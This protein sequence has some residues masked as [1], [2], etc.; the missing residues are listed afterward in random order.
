MAYQRLTINKPGYK[1]LPSLDIGPYAAQSWEISPDKL[2]LTMKLGNNYFTPLEPTRGRIMDAEDVVFTTRR[3]ASTAGNLA[4]DFFNSVSPAAPIMSV[5]AVDAKTVQ[6]KLKEPYVAILALL[7]YSTAGAM[8]IVP[9]EA[10]TF[11]LRGYQIGSGNFYLAEYEP[12]VRLVYKR[13][14]AYRDEP[15]PYVDTVELPIV[16]EYSVALAQ[17]KAGNVHIYEGIRAEDILATKREVPDLVL[18]ATDLQAS[19][20]RAFYG[21]RP[22]VKGA[23][24][25]V[26][27]RQ[28]FSMSWDRDLYIE[29]E[30]NV[31]AFEAEGLPM[32]TGWDTCYQCNYYPDWYLDPQ[33]KDFGE[34]AKYF[35]RDI[36]EAKKLVAAAG[37][38][39]G[40]EY[41]ANIPT[42]GFGAAFT[43]RVE[44]VINMGIDAGLKPNIVPVNFNTDFRPK[45]TLA[46]GDFDGMCYVPAV[47][48]P[49]PGEY[50]SAHYHT[51]GTWFNGF[52][53]DGALTRAGD[54]WMNKTIEEMRREFDEKK[55][56]AL[57]HEFQRYD[58]KTTYFTRWPGTANGFDLAWPAISNRLTYRGGLRYTDE[59]IDD[60]KAPLKKT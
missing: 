17:L 27:V 28:A 42:T 39:N 31:S 32:T 33:G 15:K 53:P 4:P 56:I 60:T 35:K 21:F 13:N 23:F 2:T 41:D 16:S 29:S 36:A 59:W 43:P 45:F 12:S 1:E 46:K 30:Y 8:S 22:G 49:D 6:F 38:P 57:A 55:R 24:R 44:K 11:D 10:E 3:Y 9:K 7:A 51:N 25:D 48:P 18:R 14:P 54:P 34:N 58:A 50:L 20:V 5:T 52:D 37:Y 19:G 47:G 40:F 26:R